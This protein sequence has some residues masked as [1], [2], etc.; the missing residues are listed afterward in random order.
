M[1]LLIDKVFD[2]VMTD[3]IV[4][5]AVGI[6]RLQLVLS[7]QRGIKIDKIILRYFNM[8]S[9]ARNAICAIAKKNN[10]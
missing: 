5:N 8:R 3:L 1:R 7:L 10:K 2:D 6:S 4:S 9:F